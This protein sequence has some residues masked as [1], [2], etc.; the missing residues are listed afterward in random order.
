[1]FFF[2]EFDDNTIPSFEQMIKPVLLAL[3]E[4][5]GEAKVSELD[6][7]AVELMG[8]SETIVS[9]P[10]KDSQNRTEVSYRLAWARTYLKKCGLIKNEERGIWTLTGKFNGNIDEINTSEITRLVRQEQSD[11]AS[12][13][14]ELSS[15]ESA[16]AFEKLVL[17]ILEDKTAAQNKCIITYADTYDLEYDAILPDGIDSIDGPIYCVL[18]YIHPHNQNLIK[19][20]DRI[21]LDL[22]K[23]IKTG[24]LLIIVNT[25]IQ[26]ELKEKIINKILKETNLP[27]SI[28][29]EQNL[30]RNIDPESN[31]V[32]YLISP[33]QALIEDTLSIDLTAE[34]KENKKKELTEKVKKAYK[35]Q[36]ITLFLGAGVSVASGVPLWSDLI[37]EL[38]IYMINEKINDKKLS[39]SEQRVLNQLAFNNKEDSPLTQMRYIRSA[40]SD[41]EY[42]S[43][44][45][46]VLYKN[47]LNIDTALLN[48]IT[49][50]CRPHWSYK[51]I[52]SIVTYNFDDL[53]ERKFQK[54]SI[55]HNTICTEKDMSSLE[56]LN[57]YHVHGY[58][59]S[60][61]DSIDFEV[62]LVFSEEDYHKVYKDTY[63]WSN[64]I[65]INAFRDS[66]CLFVGCSL[67]DPNLRRLLDVATRNGETPRHY[68]LLKKNTL[69]LKGRSTDSQ[70]KLVSL[71]QHIDDNIREG[72]YRQ[73]GL[74]I[75]WYDNHTE[76][77]NILMKLLD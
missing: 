35:R 18:K 21:M 5:G 42:Y 20:I 76:I 33:K 25:I 13:S 72:Y 29:D 50:I 43:L 49:E 7:K 8:L 48:A 9:I 70:K 41:E 74:N 28:W 2:F 15:I 11:K 30:V 3:K 63:S 51:G 67:T 53:I 56:K 1:M 14:N 4:L 75:I 60:Q 40:F 31:Y 47:N 57:I 34:E 16:Q 10:H 6:S 65:Q 77:P 12:I 59:P 69:E 26:K 68:A 19:I 17:S 61:L 22:D 66:T 37:R 58:L 46:T 24:H 38:L 45:H 23:T 73:L 55:E 44:V 39:S 27:V 36:D 62:N 52:K 64:L 32:K 71:Y 54:S